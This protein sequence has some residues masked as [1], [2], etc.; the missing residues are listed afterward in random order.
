[1]R[2]FWFVKIKGR[3]PAIGALP[4]IIGMHKPQ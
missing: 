4:P 3:E 2:P 1:M